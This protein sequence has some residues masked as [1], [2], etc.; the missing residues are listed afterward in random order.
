MEKRK[1]KKQTDK[2]GG[3]DEK[4][5][6]RDKGKRGKMKQEIHRKGERGRERR[7]KRRIKN[8]HRKGWER[9]GE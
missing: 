5:Y 1:R 6:E 8:V 7:E 2:I 4:E 3:K 9:T